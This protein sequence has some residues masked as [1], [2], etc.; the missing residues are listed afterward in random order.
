MEHET[1]KFTDLKT[2]LNDLQEDIQF[3]DSQ[4][5]PDIYKHSYGYLEEPFF[6]HELFNYWSRVLTSNHFL[7]GEWI[8]PV[9]KISREYMIIGDAYV[10]YDKGGILG[11]LHSIEDS[12]PSLLEDSP[13][14]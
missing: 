13:N 3:L 10:A 4:P 2:M 1:Y 6:S 7:F 12:L 9:L 5:N 14:E 11:M 8:H